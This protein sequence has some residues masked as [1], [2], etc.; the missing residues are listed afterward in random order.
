[1]I[2]DPSSNIKIYRYKEVYGDI[3]AKL[4][5]EELC[6]MCLHCVN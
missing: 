5:Y 1:M 4:E 2:W 6:I 3:K